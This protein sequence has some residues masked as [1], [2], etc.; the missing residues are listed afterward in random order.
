M[1][2]KPIAQQLAEKYGGEWKTVRNGFGWYY[3]GPSGRKVRRYAQPILDWD[4]YSDTEFAVV[5]LDNKG[6]RMDV[7]TGKMLLRLK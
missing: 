1:R 5:Y 6:N 3:V 4:G 7:S 2:H